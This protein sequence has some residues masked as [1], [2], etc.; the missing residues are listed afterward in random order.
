MKTLR[1]AFILIAG[2][3]CAAPASAETFRAKNRVYVNPLNDG[4]FEVIYD[5][6]ASYEG[7]WCAAAEYAHR[8]MGV[9][10]IS[11]VVVVEP[12]GP[13][14]TKPR[15]KGAVFKVDP[16]ARNNSIVVM[17]RSLKNPGTSMSVDHAYQ[18]CTMS[19][20]CRCD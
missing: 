15:R 16:N 18:Y 12:L 1:N 11:R 14:R 20:S 7:M 9:P 10:G 17:G 8:R 6:N 4:M 3:C 2:L 13:A 19:P 5:I